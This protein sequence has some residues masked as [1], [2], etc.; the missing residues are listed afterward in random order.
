MSDQ[1]SDLRAKVWKALEDLPRPVTQE[2]ALACA[3]D[4][5]TGREQADF[6]KWFEVNGAVVVARLNG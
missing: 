3:Q 4:M 5:L 6:S 1:H 2:A